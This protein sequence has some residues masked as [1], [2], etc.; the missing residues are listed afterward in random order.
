ME[1]FIRTAGS[2]WVPRREDEP[3]WRFIRESSGK[4]RRFPN[5]EAAR[6]YVRNWHIEGAEIVPADGRDK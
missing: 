3:K 4:I 6:Q 5:R 2:I 1:C